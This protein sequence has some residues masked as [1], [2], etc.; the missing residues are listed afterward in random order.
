MQYTVH[1]SERL[2]AFVARVVNVSRGQAQQYIDAGCVYI[3]AKRVTKASL[4]L[5]VASVVHIE[6]KKEILPTATHEYSPIDLQLPIVYEDEEVF[7]I[8]KP[9]M[10]VCHHGVGTRS[11]PTLLDGIY[12]LCTIRK[13]DFDPAHSLVHR[14]D[15]ETTGCIIVAKTKAAHSAIQHQFKAR[16]V[17]KMYL[18]IVEGILEQ[19]HAR[20]DAPIGRSVHN[21]TIMRVTTQTRHRDSSTAYSVISENYEHNSSL[22]ECTLLTGRTH[23]IR[24]HFSAL[25]H[26]L[27][28]DKKYG[29]QHLAPFYLHSRLVSWQNM[30][31]KTITVSVE[32]PLEFTQ[33]CSR[34]DLSVPPESIQ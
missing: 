28:G 5:Q 32:V 31:G 20:I 21:R 18:A 34:L 9:S 10:L 7:V 6:V 29:S 24:V 27:Y 26:P 8:N 19:K 17:Q 15:K 12:Y 3:N 22:V 11:A 1:T 13:I 25:H 2:D 30:T 14:L 23:Q 16:T 33:A 4:R